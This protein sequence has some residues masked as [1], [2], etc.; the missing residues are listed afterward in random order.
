M[1][2][3]RFARCLCRRHRHVQ[4]GR[5][6]Q[7]VSIAHLLL[8]WALPD[9]E[10]IGEVAEWL[11]ALAWKASVRL[12]RTA[13]SNP[14]LSARN[15]KGPFTGPFLF[16]AESGCGLEPCSTNAAAQRHVGE[17]AAKRPTQSRPLRHNCFILFTINRQC[18]HL[19]KR[20]GAATMSTD[21]K[22][23][24]LVQDLESRIDALESQDESEFGSF[25]RADYIILALGG[26]VL[27]VIALVWAA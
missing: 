26:V 14:A 25:S 19:D 23:Q 5:R 24:E 16:L 8:V 22:D 27:P 11:K 6:A 17:E 20:G 18:R 13:G 9:V 10:K 4:Q 1:T 21:D 15:Q 7:N 12:Y 2:L 3:T